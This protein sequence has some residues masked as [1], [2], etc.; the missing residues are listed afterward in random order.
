MTFE[1][2]L[3][4]LV[5]TL[6]TTADGQFADEF[7]FGRQ[8]DNQYANQESR[9]RTEPVGAFDRGAVEHRPDPED[10]RRFQLQYT[11]LEAL[12]LIQENVNSDL[13]YQSDDGD[14][15]VVEYQEEPD[16]YPDSYRGFNGHSYQYGAPVLDQLERLVEPVPID[17][18]SV[19]R[20]GKSSVG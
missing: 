1:P 6:F 9:Q 15:S 13:G 10:I 20:N 8:D 2:C 5:V 3:I 7:L 14:R 11:R 4:V 18:S 17:P 12:N 16:T 19:T